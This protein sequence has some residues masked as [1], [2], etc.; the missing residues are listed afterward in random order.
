MPK[1]VEHEVLSWQHSDPRAA[2]DRAVQALVEGKLVVFPTETGPV[3]T[4]KADVIDAVEALLGRCSSAAL[5]LAVG[6][7]EQAFELL[8]GMSAAGRRLARRCWH[9]PVELLYSGSLARDATRLPEPVSERAAAQGTLALRCPR[10]EA[11][12]NAIFE[13]KVPL[14]IAALSA[15][16][17]AGADVALVID[18]GPGRFE[19]GPTVVRVN[20]DWEVVRE[21]AVSREELR[22][23]AGCLVLFVCTGNTCRS[24]LAEALCKKK[25]CDRLGCAP[26]ELPQRGFLI[27]SAGVSAFEGDEAAACAVEVAR[28]HGADLSQHTSKPLDRH[29]AAQTD[30]LLCMTQSHLQTLRS[31]FSHLGCEPRQLSPEG[32][33]LPDPIGQEETVYRS[34]AAQIW[35]DLDPLVEQ[36]LG[37]SQTIPG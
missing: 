28:E 37:A 34:C 20:G 22:L 19:Q 10:H 35:K 24:P 23:L 15:E 33:D 4:A 17:A 30:H 31:Y 6:S 13:L 12:L 27:L 26:Q 29:L 1:G 5:T 25:L 3:V 2:L 16:R 36:L 18:D 7:P 14:V 21:G 32:T 9:G 11:I 8:P